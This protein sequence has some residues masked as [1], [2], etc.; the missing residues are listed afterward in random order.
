MFQS[1]RPTPPRE[2]VKAFTVQP[3]KKAAIRAHFAGSARDSA[4][5]ASLYRTLVNLHMSS[6]YAPSS[7]PSGCSPLT[8]AFAPVLRT[9]PLRGD[10]R[11]Q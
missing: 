9:R 8:K 4:L 7:T 10:Y 3:E 6:H 11:E 1:K 2:T 5:F